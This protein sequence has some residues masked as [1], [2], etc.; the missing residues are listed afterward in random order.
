MA[1]LQERYRHFEDRTG[2][3]PVGTVPIR[4]ALR[5]IR[6]SVPTMRHARQVFDLVREAL[7]PR[8]YWEGHPAH[9]FALF[10]RDD[11]D[12]EWI[13]VVPLLELLLVQRDFVVGTFQN[14]DPLRAEDAHDA[15]APLPLAQSDGPDIVPRG[16]DM[17]SGTLIVQEGRSTFELRYDSRGLLQETGGTMGD[18]FILGRYPGTRPFTADPLARPPV[19]GPPSILCQPELE[20]GYTPETLAAII[21]RAA[22]PPSTARV[23][24]PAP[25]PGGCSASGRW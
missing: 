22:R 21:V 25:I 4:A 8:A 19:V 6:R 18:S 11:V 3:I 13:C 15:P 2:L 10:L 17:T 12:P 1:D 14:A 7:G 16:D 5:G 9:G 23:R 20:E 24:I